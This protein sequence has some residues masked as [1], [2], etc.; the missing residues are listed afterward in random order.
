MT[1]SS[2]ED[3]CEDIVGKAQRGLQLSDQVLAD[4]ADITISDLIKI[5]TGAFNEETV[6]KLAGPLFLGEEALVSAGNNAWAPRHQEPLEGLHSF[7][8]DYHD[9]TVNAY[10]IWDPE[11]SEAAAFDTGSKCDPILQFAEQKS[12]EIKQIFLTHSHGDHIQDLD[13][14]KNSTNAKVYASDKEPVPGT[15]LFTE[16]STFKI[17]RLSVETMLTWGHSIGGMTFNI[18]GLGSPIAIVGDSLFAGSMGGGRVSYPDALKNNREKILVLPDETIVCPGH[19]PQT[20]VAEEKQHNPFF[21]E[22]NRQ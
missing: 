13:K 17:G 8:T 9:M 16:G 7:T 2:L 20:T 22:L 12:L 4:L 14:L 10:L 5:K 15:E 11:T 6:R 19:G 3:F 18:L 21:P 1:K